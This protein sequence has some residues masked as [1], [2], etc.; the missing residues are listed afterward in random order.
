MHQAKENN[1]IQKHRK[2]DPSTTNEHIPKG[3]DRR[4]WVKL[5]AAAQRMTRQELAA[6]WLLAIAGHVSDKDFNDAL[7]DMTHFSKEQIIGIL[8]EVYPE[9]AMRLIS[10]YSSPA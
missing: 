6:F 5:L 7:E 2:S 1:S 4:V 10:Q 9:D 8:D 3:W